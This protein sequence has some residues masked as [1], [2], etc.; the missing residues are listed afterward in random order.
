MGEY[1]IGQKAEDILL[2]MAQKNNE[3][4][5]VVGIDPDTYTFNVVLKAWLNS[6]EGGFESARRAESILRLMAKLQRAGHNY[7]RPD[8]VRFLD[9]FAGI[10]QCR[11][12]RRRSLRVWKGC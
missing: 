12:R 8:A 5:G 10:C 11:W 6:G 7:V 9:M 2:G 4:E 1:G 3:G